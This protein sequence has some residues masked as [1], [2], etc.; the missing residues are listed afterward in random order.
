MLRFLTGGSADRLTRARSTRRCRQLRPGID[1]LE[2]RRLLAGSINFIPGSGLSG[3]IE[4]RAEDAGNRALVFPKPTTGGTLII[5]EVRVELF[6]TSGVLQRRVDFLSTLVVQISFIGGPGPDTLVNST[7]IPTYA[8]GGVGRNSLTGGSGNDHLIGGPGA[9]VL[10]GGAGNDTLKGEGGH[11]VV[12]GGGGADLLS[13]GWGNDTIYGGAGHD[14]IYGFYPPATIL[15]TPGTSDDD[16]LY[17]EAGDDSLY[18]GSGNDRLYGG[19]GKDRLDGQGGD[20]ILVSIGGGQAD[21]VNGGAGFDS[22]WVDAEDTESIAD[23]DIWEHWLGNVHR[24]ASFASLRVV[25]GTTTTVT[26]VSRELNGQNLVD[27]IADGTYRDFGNRSLFATAG[28]TR[29]DVFQGA[30]GD[31]YYLATLSAVADANPNRIRQSVVDLGDGTF[32]ARFYRDGVETYVRVDNDFATNPGGTLRYAGFGRQNS[33]WVA[34][35]EKAWAF[36]RRNEG[37]YA[38]TAFGWMSEAFTALG[39]SSTDLWSASTGKALLTHIQAQLT[40]GKAVTFATIP[41]IPVGCP[42]IGNHAYMVVGV[43]FDAAGAP[44]GLRLRNPW[45]VDGA[46]NDGANDGYVTLTTAQAKQVFRV[47]TSAYVI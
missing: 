32:A 40:D 44:T 3:T 12:N 42:V 27:P 4:I 37:T 39:T 41:T 13:G 7:A 1:D 17:G 24:V 23:A 10:N 2:A 47:V 34:V 21:W 43:N 25:N 19:A 15:T 18:G 36:F 11:D 26:A 5:P 29:D 28:P 31:C 46:D 8:N 9:D 38:S 20:D 6:S 35:L 16:V 14:R 33:L 45:G 30:V 22:F